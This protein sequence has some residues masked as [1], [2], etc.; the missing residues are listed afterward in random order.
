MGDDDGG[1]VTVTFK[2]SVTVNMPSLACKVKLAFDASHAA[3]TFAVIVPLVLTILE[4]VTA[5]TVA[6]VA[7]LQPARRIE[8]LLELQ[9]ATARSCFPSPLK[10]PMAIDCGELPT[11]TLVVAV[12]PP[13]PSPTRIETLPA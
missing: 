8:T 12:K 2:V 7:S 11:T 4:T 1:A 9:L 13:L 6:E 5:L 3:K 10:S